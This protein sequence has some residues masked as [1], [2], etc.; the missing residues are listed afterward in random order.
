MYA[1]EESFSDKIK[2]IRIDELKAL[3]KTAFLYSV[4]LSITPCITVVAVIVA[5]IALT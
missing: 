3:K 5:V 1:W 2:K 4:N